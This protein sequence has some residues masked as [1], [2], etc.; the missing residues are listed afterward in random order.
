MESLDSKLLKKFQ[1]FA[2]IIQLWIGLTNFQL[3]KITLTIA[4]I[5]W[6]ETRVEE[7][8][9]HGWTVLNIIGMIVGSAF[10]LY[11][12]YRITIGEKNS[13]Q[14]PLFQSDLSI[15]FVVFRRF[16]IYFVIL[17][18]YRLV[19]D[20]FLPMTI[21]EK[22]GTAVH[23]VRVSVFVWISSIGE[24]VTFYLA[25]C[26]PKPRKPSRLKEWL[27]KTNL[28]PQTQGI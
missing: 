22:P 3:A 17:A 8:V 25:S 24:W 1:K 5:G 13:H 27:E 28:K 26:T 4:L 15:D 10:Y 19:T 2:D 23:N 9:W 16:A 7:T 18:T 12:T 20:I 21:D 11:I 14:N 6:L